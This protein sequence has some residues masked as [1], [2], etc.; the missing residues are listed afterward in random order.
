MSVGDGTGLQVLS[1]AVDRLSANA[2]SWST[3]RLLDEGLDL[4]RDAAWADGCAL[5]RTADD[6]A[7]TVASRPANLP[8]DHGPIP[9]EWLPWGLAPVSPQRFLLVDD[10]T[11]LPVDPSGRVRLGELGIRSCA[12]LP[13]RERS[14][15]VGALHLFWREP[16]LAWDDDRGRLLRN[17]GR[18]LLDQAG[19]GVA[20]IR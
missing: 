11:R 20:G 14:T 2:E 18:F 19:R 12:Y 13:L 9:V 4:V 7:R 1:A 15:L 6:E 16:R 17:L 3:A 8:V 5:V 10:A